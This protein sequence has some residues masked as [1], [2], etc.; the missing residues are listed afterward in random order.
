MLNISFMALFDIL[1]IHIHIEISELTINAGGG[2]GYSVATSRL[3]L[4][5]LGIL[6]MLYALPPQNNLFLFLIG[7][8]VWW[9]LTLFGNPKKMAKAISNNT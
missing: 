4:A 2:K 9:Y 6:I 8:G 3:A 5:I 1:G 7:L